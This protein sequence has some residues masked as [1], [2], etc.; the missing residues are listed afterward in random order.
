[1]CA[2]GD[3]SLKHPP[4]MSPPCTNVV[5][6]LLFSSAS[7]PHLSEREG[8]NPKMVQIEAQILF[9]S[10]KAWKEN[11]MGTKVVTSSTEY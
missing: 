8:K 5:A 1:M 7:S 9:S 11:A 3:D 10:P 2:K 4:G 6:Q